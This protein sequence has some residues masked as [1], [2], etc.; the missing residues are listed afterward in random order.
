LKRN[1]KET[2]SQDGWIWLLMTTWLI[3]GINRGRGQ[4]F[5]CC[6]E[7]ANNVF[8]VANTSLRLHLAACDVYLPV[9]RIRDIY[10]GSD[11]FPSRIPDPHQRIISPKKW[12]LRSMKTKTAPTTLGA[13][14]AASQSICINAQLYSTCD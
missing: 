8:R 12:L 10:P 3:S 5:H 11:F 13:I 7:K 6:N 9:L 2:V 4:F 14:Q 1:V